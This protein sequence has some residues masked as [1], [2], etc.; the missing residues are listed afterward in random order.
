MKIARMA[1]AAAA[2]LSLFAADAFPDELELIDGTVVQVSVQEV[3]EVVIVVLS[4]P[5]DILL[6]IPRKCLTPMQN[7]KLN[8]WRLKKD[9]RDPEDAEVQFEYGKWCL[10]FVDYDSRLLEKAKYH[11]DAA[12]KINPETALRIE[13]LLINRNLREHPTDPSK[14]W[15]TDEEFHKLKGD[16]WDDETREWISP[17]E[18]ANRDKEREKDL[19]NR[20]LPGTKPEEFIFAVPDAVRGSLSDFIDKKVK[21]WG[22]V[23]AV[24]KSYPDENAA[25]TKFD[26]SRYWKVLLSGDDCSSVYFDYRKPEIKKKLETFAQG[27]RVIVYGQVRVEGIR[28]V[29]EGADIVMR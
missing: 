5:G 7:Y 10:D 2:L 6:H 18:K 13:Q 21:I 28:F 27:D 25:K 17:E 12:K 15:V 20:L 1:G 23:V 26:Q 19:K 9:D 8:L 14:G 11:L 22:R 24:L 16:I 29:L 4:K 3:H